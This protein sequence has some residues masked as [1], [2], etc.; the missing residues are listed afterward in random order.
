MSSMPH[1]IPTAAAAALSSMAPLHTSAALP[2]ADSRP[3][4]VALSSRHASRRYP[5]PYEGCTKTYTNNTNVN[6]H[7]KTAHEHEVRFTCAACQRGF[8]YQHELGRHNCHSANPPTNPPPTNQ[9]TTHQPST[10]DK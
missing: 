9:P 2:A 5:C 6:R 10:H 1:T 8:Y 3:S 4:N 7:V